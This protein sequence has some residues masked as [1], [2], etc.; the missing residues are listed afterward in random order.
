[1]V[2]R[3]DDLGCRDGSSPSTSFLWLCRQRATYMA[4]AKRQRTGSGD[5][6]EWVRF[7]HYSPILVSKLHKTVLEMRGMGS[8]MQEM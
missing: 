1:M 4:V 7:L 6:C 8:A 3:P 2:V 5:E